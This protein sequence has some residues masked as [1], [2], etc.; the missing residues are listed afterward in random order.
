MTTVTTAKAFRLSQSAIKAYRQ[1]FAGGGCPYR[2]KLRYIDHVQPDDDGQWNA[3]KKGLLFERMVIGASR[4]DEPIL[5][6]KLKSG[7]PTQVERD[8]IE[9]ADNA[10]AIID[11]MPFTI[12]QVQPTLATDTRQG[13][14]DCFITIDGRRAIMD[15]KYTETQPDDRFRGWGDLSAM[16]HTQ[17]LDYVDLYH[18]VYGEYVPFYYL[19]FGKDGWVRFIKVNITA[20]SLQAHRE[21]VEW[22]IEQ[23][24]NTTDYPATTSQATCAMCPVANKCDRRVTLPVTEILEL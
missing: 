10:R 14:P 21:S 17:A 9:L 18:E 23:I 15:L 19:V 20:D 16:D 13:H 11:K 6:P 12:D 5:I 22:I 8:L 3:L 7:E 2:F 1:E 4:S 24:Q